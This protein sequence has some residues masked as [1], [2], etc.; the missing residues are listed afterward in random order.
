MSWSTQ[1]FRYCERGADPAFWGEPIN[2]LTNGAFLL[3][4][5]AAGIALVRHRD[6]ARGVFQTIAV[7]LL[8]ALVFVIG[9]GSFL[10][11][12]YATRW[13]A[14]ADTMP[15]GIFMLAYLAYA[16]RVYVK[17]GWLWVAIGLALFVAA[18]QYAGTI[19]CKPGLISVTAAARGPCLNG[20]VGY[21]PAFLA[22]VGIGAVL[23]VKGHGAANYLLAAGMI[24]LASMFFRTVDFEVCSL[25]RIA[26]QPIGTHFLWHV[27]NA[28]TL[29]L[30]LRA[31]VFYG[32]QRAT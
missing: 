28:L 21:V 2:A 30:L 32:R 24:F 7:A 29:Y 15:I 4:A 27:L 20:T 11:H 22:M 16:L 8:I 3:A 1:L 10:F 31:A 25:T 19:Q 14:L 6:D 5:V 12:T 18:L 17:L 26:G 9:I 23:K 13:A